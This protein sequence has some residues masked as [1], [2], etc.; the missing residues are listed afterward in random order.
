MFGQDDNQSQQ[1]QPGQVAV[2]TPDDAL[3]AA[4]NDISGM[5]PDDADD[6]PAF[7]ETPAVNASPAGRGTP[8]HT[9][10]ELIGIKQEALQSL[11]PL[12]SHLQQSPEEHFRT[13]MMMIQAADDQGLIPEA[14]EAAKAIT[15]DK[16]RAQAFLDVI[17]EINYFTNQQH[18]A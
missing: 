10:E 5:M 8:A 13:L 6:T 17:N 11:K 9:P 18:A 15:D 14:Y 4:A 3:S 2:P 16:A 7:I 12:V 1:G